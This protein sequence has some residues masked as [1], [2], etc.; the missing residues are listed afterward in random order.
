MFKISHLGFIIVQLSGVRP[1]TETSTV[2]AVTPTKTDGTQHV[3]VRME[4]TLDIFIVHHNLA[5]SGQV[6]SDS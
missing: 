6:I 2:I 4:E 3:V 5:R 1:K